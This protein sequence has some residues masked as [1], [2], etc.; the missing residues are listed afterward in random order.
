MRR[1]KAAF[2]V[3]QPLAPIVVRALPG[4]IGEPNKFPAG[5][6]E[7]TYKYLKAAHEAG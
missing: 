2:E 7:R 6:K 1:R 3:E 5:L 4:A